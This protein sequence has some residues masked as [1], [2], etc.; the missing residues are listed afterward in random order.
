MDLLT[1]AAIR[2]HPGSAA[3][4]AVS[5]TALAFFRLAIFRTGMIFLR[6]S[7]GRTSYMGS[8]SAM[9]RV[10]YCTRYLPRVSGLAFSVDL[11]G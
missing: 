7:F 11:D 9:C 3:T 4:A 1:G 6:F 5:T 2:E 10:D 8:Y